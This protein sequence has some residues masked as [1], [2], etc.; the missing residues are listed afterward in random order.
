MHSSWTNP[1]RLPIEPLKQKEKMPP[2]TVKDTCEDPT[3]DVMLNGK[4]LKAS[5]EGEEQRQMNR[6]NTSLRIVLEVLPGQSDKE[7][8]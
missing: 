4:R 3:V 7:K 5:P 6:H 1:T 8:M 2:H